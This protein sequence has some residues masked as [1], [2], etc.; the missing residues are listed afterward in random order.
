[1]NTDIIGGIITLLSGAIVSVLN[2][3][4]SR[5]LL[6][7]HTDKYAFS[8]LLRQVIQIGYLVGVYFVGNSLTSCNI[9]YL[10]VG[11]VLGVTVPM[12]FFT[13]SLVKL[14]ETLKSNKEE[15]GE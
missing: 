12:F 7:K 8:T 13:H 1:M 6:L 5:Y 4:L 10:L 9:T 15:K 3:L 2:Y 11:A 14:N